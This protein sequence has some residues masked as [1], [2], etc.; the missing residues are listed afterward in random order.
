MNAGT[1]TGARKWSARLPLVVGFGAILLLLGTLGAWSIGTEIA[2]A[3]VAPGQVR[4]ES[5]RQVVQHP[6][7][8]VVGE[9]LVRDGD[10]VA[11][12]ETLIRLDDTFLKSELVVIERQLLELFARR[13]R[14]EAEQSGAEA[15]DFSNPPEATLVDPDWA[16]GQIE[17]QRD[18]FEARV[19]SRAKEVARLREQA[20]QIEDQIEGMDAQLAAL[21]RQRELIGRE[22]EDLGTL[23]E[24][25]LVQQGRVLEL[26]REAARL[27]GQIGQLQASRAEARGRIAGIEIEILRLGDARR[28][29]AI[30]RLRDLRYSEID[31]EA[32][33][34]RL[35]EQ[36]ARLDLRAPME[37]RVFGSRVFARQSVVQP[38]EPVMYIVPDGQP[39][40]V[41]ARI[42]PIDVDEVFVGQP[43]SLRFSTFDQRS[44]PDI[45]GEVARVSADTVVD[46]VTGASFYEAVILP[47]AEELA[48]LE[49]VAMIP[50]L[51][52]EAFIRTGERT[53]LSYLTS[54]LTSYFARAFRDG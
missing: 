50:G 18:L 41:V 30:S 43:V 10:L 2:G 44:T 51:P 49:D 54:P 9:I 45:A 16:E 7:G 25:G 23:L 17:G 35:Y 36:L 13:A 15:P 29:E 47:D 37:G 22:E 46:E 40:E 21:A 19:E 3:V 6:D 33:R 5:Q 52:V 26:Q 4:V 14:L 28:E 31:L 39:M 34:I 42:D 24:R 1:D 12:G 38:A 53:P 8:G 11:E 20:G 48:A 32:R 27:E